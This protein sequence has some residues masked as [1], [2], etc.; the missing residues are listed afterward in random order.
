MPAAPII[1]ARY[2]MATRFELVLPLDD[3][4]DEAHARHLRAAGENA[5]D[6]IA[7]WHDRLS[8]FDPGSFIS[9]LNANAAHRDIPC[10]AEIF[11]LLTLCRQV[12]AAS[13]G[14]FDPT[15][16][17]LMRASG[18]R[19]HSA[20]GAQ[21]ASL[22]IPEAR[23]APSAG[24]AE[25]AAR[26]AHAR[27]ATGFDKVILDDRRRTVRFAR[28]GVALDLGA[29]G[30]GFAI[31]LAMSVL[32]HSGVTRALLHG[33]ASSIAAM[34]SPELSPAQPAGARTPV[35]PSPPP[36]P[37]WPIQLGPDADDPVLV[38]HNAALGVSSPSG[39]T[40]DTPAGP[41]G[42]VLDPRTGHSVAALHLAAVIA[43]SCA[44]ADAWSTALL[45]AG[46]RPTGM[47][48]DMTTLIKPAQSPQLA[49][50]NAPR[51]R[52]AGPS[53]AILSRSN[54]TAQ[55]PRSPS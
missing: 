8:F 3:P 12:W 13:R 48:G 4:A 49:S 27:E 18:F 23:N 29:I 26:I 47:P 11:E 9:H 34:G 38:L 22:A 19:D 46:D 55:G 2:A 45:V 7:L 20:A 17:A 31:D 40:I 5:L 21:P 39:R 52:L 14:A 24:P 54:C 25:R 50:E 32:R 15:I 10:D 44:L 1:L 36:Q 41:R 6:E 35:S 43:G 42:H 37:G 53:F 30:K 51:W 33:G 28:P 16:A